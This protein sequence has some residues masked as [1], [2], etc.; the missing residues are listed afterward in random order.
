MEKIKYALRLLAFIIPSFLLIGCSSADSPAINQNTA[1]D[2]STKSVRNYTTPQLFSIM[3]DMG[4]HINYGNRPP[5]VNGDYLASRLRLYAS[6]IANDE[7]NSIFSDTSFK[8]ENQIRGKLTINLSYMVANG[9]EFSRGNKALISGSGNRFSIFAKQ[10]ITE[11]FGSADSIIIVSGKL[12]ETGI[13]D[14]QFA[15]FIVENHGISDF[16]ANNHG[17]VFYDADNLAEKQ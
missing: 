6:N 3:Q 16:I 10:T 15:L 17:R 9:S 1:F 14:F 8:L 12:T 13:S 5:M 11:D 2:G 7:I 4:L